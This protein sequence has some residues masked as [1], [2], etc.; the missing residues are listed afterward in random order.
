VGAWPRDASP[1][2][3]VDRR[4]LVSSARHPKARARAEFVA[5]RRLTSLLDTIHIENRN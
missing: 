3:R 2:A 1:Y 5:E 4:E